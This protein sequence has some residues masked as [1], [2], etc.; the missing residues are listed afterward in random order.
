MINLGDESNEIYIFG[1]VI[2]S[3]GKLCNQTWKFNIDSEMWEKVEGGHVPHD[4]D[5]CE[6]A[7][8][9]SNK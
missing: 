5:T 1:G 4:T 8:N 2:S 7:E 3:N 9:E 6:S